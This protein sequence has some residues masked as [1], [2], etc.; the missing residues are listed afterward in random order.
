M[1]G[2][3]DLSG[4]SLED[5]SLYFS[6]DQLQNDLEDSDDNMMI[7]RV[8]ETHNKEF[9]ILPLKAFVGMNHIE[10]EDLC[11]S[12]SGNN[13]M[14]EIGFRNGRHVVRVVR[15]IP[16]VNQ[17]MQL[18]RLESDVDKE[19]RIPGISY[20][21][22]PLHATLQEEFG[23]KIRQDQ[24]ILIDKIS[25]EISSLV[26]EVDKDSSTMKFLDFLNL[27]SEK[28]D[29][30]SFANSPKLSADCHHLKGILAGLSSPLS[31]ELICKDYEIR[32]ELLA[33][34]K[35]HEGIIM[36]AKLMDS[37]RRINVPSRSE[38]VH[39][40]LKET[41]N[42][43]GFIEKGPLKSLM[44][45]IVNSLKKAKACRMELRN[46]AS[47][48]ILPKSVQFALNTGS[49]FVPT[50]FCPEAMQKAETLAL[51]FAGNLLKGN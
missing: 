18:C 41:A 43:K 40:L 33:V 34:V 27:K 7:G 20:I 29:L 22:A 15:D 6:D 48:F 36:A 4:E 5:P 49:S 26:S 12:H 42:I 3:Q 9:Y 24:S 45:V 17:L 46:Y 44:P 51:P 47:R 13:P 37:L 23:W 14:V 30:L 32:Q 21:K 8:P 16:L 50:L 38:P 31:K 19:T 28:A 2:Q 35:S 25:D 11:V 10:V 39:T 1:S